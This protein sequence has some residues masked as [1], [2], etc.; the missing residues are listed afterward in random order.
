MLIQLYIYLSLG[1]T[2]EIVDILLNSAASVTLKDGN[3]KTP[4]FLLIYSIYNIIEQ[5]SPYNAYEFQIQ[6]AE[7]A[8]DLIE[9]GADPN[10]T[11]FG[12][13]SAL[14]LAVECMLPNVVQILL[15]S[16]ANTDHIGKNGQNALH[17][18]FGCGGEIF[19]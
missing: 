7:I 1:S 6:V 12:E 3:G 15:E 10:S 18:C 14:H 16:S 13:D 17:S 11:P 2:R 4:L 5:C 19:L 9:K 8:S